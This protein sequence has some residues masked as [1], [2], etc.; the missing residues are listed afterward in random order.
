MNTFT[1]R[2]RRRGELTSGNRRRRTHTAEEIGM[3]ID[4]AARVRLRRAVQDAVRCPSPENV[5]V[6]QEWPSDWVAE[7]QAV[8]GVPQPRRRTSLI[9]ATA[10]ESAAPAR[11]EN[12]GK[13]SVQIRFATHPEIPP[14][15]VVSAGRS[16]VSR[17]IRNAE[18]KD[19]GPGRHV[20]ILH[21]AGTGESIPHKEQ[22]VEH[23]G[24]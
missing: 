20:E 8:Y 21:L 10:T 7:E 2:Q 19:L 13:T 22:L 23:W 16:V 3:V 5:A 11:T 15:I 24:E 12:S 1:P 14:V 9:F 6:L 18:V 4:R 17:R